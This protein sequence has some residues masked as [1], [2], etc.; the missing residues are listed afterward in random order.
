MSI[1]NGGKGVFEENTQNVNARRK[2][3]L[4]KFRR[5]YDAYIFKIQGKQISNSTHYLIK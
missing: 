4:N 5:F 1:N 3:N 2:S